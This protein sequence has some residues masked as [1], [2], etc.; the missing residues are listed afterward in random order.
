MARRGWIAGLFLVVG[1]CAQTAREEHARELAD[2]GVFLYQRGAYKEARETFQAAL[3]VRPDDPDLV[4]DLGRCYDR[5]GKADKAR[6]AYLACLQRAPDHADCRHALALLYWDSGDKASCR[7]MID[8]WLHE[9]PRL[10]APYAE[11]G[12]LLRTEGDLPLAKQRLL[13][14]LHSDPP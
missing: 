11:H 3:K 5:L 8:R 9:S 6:D 2:D 7:E 4:Y 14:A 12:S 10:A 1:A 13:H